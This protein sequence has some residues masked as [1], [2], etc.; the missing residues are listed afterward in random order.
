MTILS[1]AFPFAPVS[2]H[3]S[4]GSE[5]ILAIL[6]REMTREGY[7]SVVVAAEGSRVEGILVPTPAVQGA[8]DDHARALAYAAHAQAIEH[9][10]QSFPVDLI[11]MHG[12]DFEQY[13]PDSKLPVLATLHLAPSHYALSSLSGKYQNIWFNCVSDT[14]HTAC[15]PSDRLLS[16]VHNAIPLDLIAG[17][18]AARSYCLVLGRVC[19]EKGIHIA[20]HAARQAGVELIIAGEVFQYP[21]HRRYFETSISPSL[22]ANCR[23]VGPVGLPQKC[24]LLSGA[25]GVLLPSLVAETS[26]LTAMEAAACG[27]S[28]IAFD[29]GAL[30]E[31]VED[32]RTGFIVTDSH[33]MS[34][35]IG[36]TDRINP[37]DCWAVAQKRFCSRRMFRDYAS[38]YK[39]L[40]NSTG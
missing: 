5:Q 37:D 35:A 3:T 38:C 36:R 34:Q 28:V 19:P 22:D 2:L 20:I 33:Q 14:Q 39:R 11:H 24:G 29:S 16:P 4:G 40:T 1:V 27:T 13:F 26:S 30:P 10:L 18:P 21:E 17:T 9:A 32:G 7:R 6:D 15:E 8:I 23:F 25:R 12:M 31:I